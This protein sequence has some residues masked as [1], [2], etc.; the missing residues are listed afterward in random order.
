MLTQAVQDYIKAI[1]KLQ[2]GRDPTDTVSTIMIAEMM[3][4]SGASSTSMI[5]KLAKMNLVQHTPYH[6]VE[7]TEAGEEIALE[8]IRHHRLLELFL[9]KALGYS[10]DEVDAEADKLEHVISEELEDRIDS[11]LGHP[12][13]DPHG[14][15]I[16][17]K[18]GQIQ[19]NKYQRLSNLQEG[20]PA[21]VRQVSD[22][23]PEMLRYMESLGLKPG[24]RVEVRERAP[25]KGPLQV[26]IDPGEE[27]GLGLEVAEYVYVEALADTGPNA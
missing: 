18:N 13:I 22:R 20:Q 11:R 19:K 4:V 26:R 6:G 27:H 10:W 9:S 23:N 14:A 2:K 24:A 25:F 5:K 21:I 15:P 7:L 8:V 17:N 12:T 16:P 1:Y 3:Q